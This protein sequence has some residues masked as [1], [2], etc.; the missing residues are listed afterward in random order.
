LHDSPAYVLVFHGSRDPRPHSAVTQLAELVRAGLLLRQGISVTRSH[1]FP[2]TLL[3]RPEIFLETASLEL[4]E[5]PLHQRIEEF[6]RQAEEKGATTL[7]IIPLF[8]LAGVHVVEDIPREVS[9]ARSSLPLQIKP[10]LG[11]YRGVQ[12]RVAR[13]FDRF[14][15]S[16][17]ILLSHGSRRPSG[18]ATIETL[19]ASVKATAA[20]WSV[21]PS[22]ADTIETL[23]ATGRDSIAILPYFLFPGTITDESER[24][25]LS[26]SQKYKNVNFFLGQPF[27]ATEEL[28]RILLEEAIP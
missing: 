24:Q 10:Y 5:I 23:I 20:Y 3:D 9:L 16:A 28:A 1:C 14:P 11:S 21:E 17:R 19:A 22:L 7:Q 6:A 26:L 27:G 18:R 25:I 8:L 2:V 4:S 12:K 15:D 13:E